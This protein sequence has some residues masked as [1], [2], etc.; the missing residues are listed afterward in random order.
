VTQNLRD[1]VLAQLHNALDGRLY[2][3]HVSPTTTPAEVIAMAERIK[4]EDT[5]YAGVRVWEHGPHS[6]SFQLQRVVA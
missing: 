6:V 4:A 3:W 5:L 2:V 1:D